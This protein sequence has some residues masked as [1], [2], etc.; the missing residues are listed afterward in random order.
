MTICRYLSFLFYRFLFSVA[1]SWCCILPR[2]YGKKTSYLSE[3][4]IYPLSHILQLSLTN[5]KL[6]DITG[7]VLAE[8]RDS[9]HNCAITSSTIDEEY[10]ACDSE[11]PTYV[12][13][14]ARLEGTSE[15]DS[16]SLIPLIEKWLS[17]KSSIVVARVEIS[18]DLECPVAVLS[19]NDTEG[20]KSPTVSATTSQSVLDDSGAV[21]GGAVAIILIIAL[22]IVAVSIARLRIAAHRRREPSNAVWRAEQ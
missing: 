5:E 1:P 21:I 4:I 14:R 8:L 16:G 9:C 13:Y 12:T 7:A 10:F 20:C 3:M 17:S 15:T 18:I 11:S 6:D 22:T 19:P 2:I